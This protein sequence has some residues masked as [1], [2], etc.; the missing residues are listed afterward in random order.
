MLDFSEEA[1]KSQTDSLIHNGPATL[2]VQEH[3]SPPTPIQNVQELTPIR[4]INLFKTMRSN[5]A[6]ESNA[7][8]LQEDRQ[9]EKWSSNGQI[10]ANFGKHDDHQPQISSSFDDNDLP[11]VSKREMPIL[12]SNH[13]L[14]TPSSSS[15]SVSKQQIPQKRATMDYSEEADYYLNQIVSLLAHFRAL[16]K[17]GFERAIHLDMELKLER[18]NLN[19]QISLMNLEKQ[20][21]ISMS[22]EI[23]F[24]RTTI[25][26]L[27][28]R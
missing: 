11:Q 26:E 9:Y 4:P 28:T 2:K 21:K 14:I 20:S 22:E 27:Q 16:G 10:S 1:T 23:K 19:Q 6:H 3:I 25:N 17:S 18:E 5:Y 12:N 8:G 7:N 24:M 15:L 13:G